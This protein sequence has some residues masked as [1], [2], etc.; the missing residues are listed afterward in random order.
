AVTDLPDVDYRYVQGLAGC[1]AGAGVADDRRDGCAGCNEFLG[2]DG[3]ALNVLCDRAKDVLR[4]SLGAAV[5][6]PVWHALGLEPFDVVSECSEHGRDIASR[7][8]GIDTLDALD[9]LL[10]HGSPLL[11][12]PEPEPTRPVGRGGRSAQAR[13]RKPSPR[14]RRDSRRGLSR[15]TA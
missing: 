4:H 2:R 7:E 13:P 9:A 3:E 11:D 8:P 15:S 12:M 10:T 1:L 14:S 6:A 5:Q